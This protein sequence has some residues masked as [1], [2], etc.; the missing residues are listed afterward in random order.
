M[1]KFISHLIFRD[2]L[3]AIIL[4]ALALFFYQQDWLA[5]L[6]NQIYDLELKAFSRPS[7]HDIVII[8]I[9]ERSLSAIGRWPWARDVHAEFI[10]KLTITQPKAIGLDIIFAEPDTQNPNADDRLVQAVKKNGRV[11]LP[12]LP[13]LPS[14]GD[15]IKITKP[16]PELAVSAGRLGHVDIEIDT[17]GVAR[18]I[19]LKAG[20]QG[21]SWPPFSL[22]L[23]QLGSAEASA[24]YSN[25]LPEDFSSTTYWT[26]KRPVYIPFVRRP[27][28]FQQFSYVD[29]L[30]NEGIRALL[31]DKYVIVGM[32]AAGMAQ[33]F[34]T[35]VMN[36]AHLMTGVEF[37]AHVLDALLNQRTI[38]ALDPVWGMFL[39]VFLAPLPL[40]GFRY[41]TKFHPLLVVLLALTI[42]VVLG[43]LLLHQFYLRYDQAAVVLTLLISYL[44]YHWRSLKSIKQLFF[45]EKAKALAAL[46]AIGDAV[47]STD[48]RGIVKYMNP[49]AETLIDCSLDKVRGQHIDSLFTVNSDT[50]DLT[51][52]FTEMARHLAKG[53]E[54]RARSPRIITNL[55]GK[56]R[57]V[58]IRANPIKDASK[59]ISGMVFA[60]SDITENLQINQKLAYLT[61]HDL[62]TELPNRLLCEDRLS[63]AINASNRKGSCCAVLF[64][65]LDDFKKI[66]EGMGHAIGDQV[67][68]ELAQ[69]MR[70]IVRNYDSVARWGGDEFVIVLEQLENEEIVSFIAQKIQ[71]QL[72][73]PIYLGG[74]KLF[75]TSS[76]GISL[77]PKDALTEENL[78][79]RANAAMFRA[80]ETGGNKF[81]YFSRS[82]NKKARQRLILEKEMHYALEEGGF[83]VFY[84]PQIELKTSRIIGAE[85]LLRWNHNSRG[86]ILPDL[87]IPL[88]EEIG[89][90]NPIGEWVLQTVCQQ[91]TQWQMQGLPNIN[92]AVNLSP[93]QFLQTDLCDIIKRSIQDNQLNPCYLDLEI[94]ESLMIKDVDQIAEMLAAIK[95]LGV[96]IAIDD[97]GTGYSSLSFL[98]RFPID[99]LKIDKSFIN[100]ITTSRNDASI[101][102]SLIALA[103]NMDMKVVAEGVEHF[104]Q[105]E[106]LKN[107]QCDIVQGY[108]FSRPLTAEA[109]T[110]LLKKSQ[111]FMTK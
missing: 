96:S 45:R 60:L 42:T 49:S 57:A 68:K 7:S 77:Y 64:V 25:P 92:A 90:I 63:Q 67:L 6:D 87:F 12:V 35:P 95:S 31:R 62:I 101:A 40:A 82:L 76:M 83:E 84:Q 97:F 3:L 65:D 50:N 51:D 18:S 73:Q 8:N 54:I 37:N 70:A 79:A 59:R 52:E 19:F 44:I 28:H 100:H 9:D 14:I 36:N 61:T 104:D 32:A 107:K 11:V 41:L 39:T 74:Q 29:V 111:G 93:R 2:L 80:K 106:F 38:T 48:S 13:E 4:S 94:T 55:K 71:E 102:K 17:D 108:Y 22:A 78:I 1:R 33:V 81:C 21:S 99:Q 103:H 5:G 88:A 89:L 75:V 24:A 91:L 86:C 30:G 47:I 105:L 56:Q 43:I 69:R 85:A 66:N 26:R 58:Q 34:A 27:E 46:H 16:W 23:M 110:Q 109:M 20:L 10:N 53:H 72:A 98:T 15:V